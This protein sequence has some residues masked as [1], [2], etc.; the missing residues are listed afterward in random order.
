MKFMLQKQIL[1][2]LLTQQGLKLSAEAN[3]CRFLPISFLQS[4]LSVS[5]VKFLFVL[6]TVH[7]LFRSQKY[8]TLVNRCSGV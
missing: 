4:L 8:C 1:Q 7:L 2:Q 6:V 3:D 5:K